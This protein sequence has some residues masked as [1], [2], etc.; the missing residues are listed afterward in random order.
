MVVVGDITTGHKLARNSR[1]NSMK[2][3]S[4]WRCEDDGAL[5]RPKAQRRVKTC[6]CK[7]V[8]SCNLYCKLEGIETERDTFMIR[9]RDSV[10]RRA[11]TYVYKGMTRQRF[12]DN[13]QQL[14]SQAKLI[15]SLVIETLA[16]PTQLDI[17]FYLHRRGR[18][19]IK[20]PRVPCSV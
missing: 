12:R 6:R 7:S 8:L 13:R 16:I 19:S 14:E 17:G 10:N 2:I 9:P 5:Q 15:H 4:P 20:T 11:S 18:T 1:I 3:R